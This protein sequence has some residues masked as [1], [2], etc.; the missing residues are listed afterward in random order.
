MRHCI[1]VVVTL[2]LFVF[3]SQAQTPFTTLIKEPTV[4]GCQSG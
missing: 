3:E 2:L 4:S 1:V